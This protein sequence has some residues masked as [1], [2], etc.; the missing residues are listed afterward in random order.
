MA[1][2]KAMRGETR[3]WLLGHVNYRG[4]DCLIWPFSRDDKGY[5]LVGIGD[6]KI[7]KASRVMCRMAHG[8]PPTAKHHAAHS[9]NKGH[10]GCVNP[11]HLSWKTPRENTMDAVRS[12]KYGS[13]VGWVGKLKAAQVSEI[14]ALAGI[15]TNIE[16]GLI[17]KV[18]A[19][20]IAKIRRGETWKK[21]A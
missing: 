1:K 10:L 14:K 2:A 9:C 11:Q 18:H 4:E 8:E 3:L 15:L 13:G 21:V 20:T 7:G 17:Y 12:G 6:R 19:E 16:L 5:G